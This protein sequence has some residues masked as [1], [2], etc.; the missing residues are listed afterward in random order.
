MTKTFYTIF[1]EQGELQDYVF[2]HESDALDWVAGI[3]REEEDDLEHADID[4][5]WERAKTNGWKLKQASLK[6]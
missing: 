2:A 1:D 3:M 5:A 4:E 6:G